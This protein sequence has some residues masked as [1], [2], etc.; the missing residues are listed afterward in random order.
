M[1][2]VIRCFLGVKIPAET[3]LRRVLKELSQ[4]GRPLKAVEPDSLHVT[5]NFLGDTDPALLPEIKTAVD[6]AAKKQSRAQLTV[7]GLGVFP[8]MQR[9]STVW[10]GL[11]GDGAKTMSAIVADLGNLLENL[12]FAREERA[13]TPHVTLARVKAK[14][15]ETLRQVGERN[16]KTVFNTVTCEEIEILRSELGPDGSKYTVLER[17]PLL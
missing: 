9:P 1:A 5:L 13:F 6:A 10:A 12:G 2:D 14:P 8:H 3:S 15:P 16:A 4:M 11:A 7:T 17:C